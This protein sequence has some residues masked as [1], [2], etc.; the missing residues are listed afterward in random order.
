MIP[1]FQGLQRESIEEEG[2]ESKEW[3]HLGDRKSKMLNEEGVL[4]SIVRILLKLEKPYF[5]EEFGILH[6]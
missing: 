2:K 6:E 5:E 3:E 4:E 1:D